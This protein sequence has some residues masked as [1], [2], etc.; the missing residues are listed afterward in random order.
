MN[1]APLFK[2]ILIFVNIF[3]Y[4]RSGIL[5]CGKHKTYFEIKPNCILWL[6]LHTYLN[7]LK[8]DSQYSIRSLMYHFIQPIQQK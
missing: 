2:A 6:N 7:Y 3:E 4:I 8:Y 5:L 1:L